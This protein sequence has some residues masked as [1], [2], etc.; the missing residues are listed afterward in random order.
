MRRTKEIELGESRITVKELTLAEIRNW[1]AEDEQAEE[2]DIVG[3]LLLDDCP[4]ADLLRFC[5]A[6]AEQI[7]GMTQ[8]E[9]HTLLG[10]AKEMNPDFFHL[11]SKLLR[12]VAGYAKSS[13][14]APSPA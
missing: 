11:R 3:A 12:L 10:V 14:S 8:S 7:D 2:R 4:L 9:L 1:L 5:D 6:T 13:S